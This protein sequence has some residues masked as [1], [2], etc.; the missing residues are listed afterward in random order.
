VTSAKFPKPYQALK[1]WRFSTRSHHCA[2]YI[3]RFSQR[4]LDIIE[5]GE[6]ANRGHDRFAMDLAPDDVNF[7]LANLQPES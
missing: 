3:G 7:L 5:L 6:I 2:N 1:W 4:V